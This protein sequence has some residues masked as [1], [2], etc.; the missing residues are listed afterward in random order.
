MFHSRWLLCV[1]LMLLAALSGA[2]PTAD[3]AT[4][5][6]DYAYDT[7][8]F[9]STG[10]TNGAQARAA[11]ESAASFYSGILADTLAEIKPL[12]YTSPR[13]TATW[14][15]TM[16]FSGPSAAGTISLVDRTIPTDEIRVYVGS[17][18][19]TGT[20]LAVGGPGGYSWDR[21]PHNLS[22]AISTDLTQIHAN[23]EAFESA[24]EDRGEDSG[25]ARWGGAISF[26]NDTNWHFNHTT[27]P[28]ADTTDFLTV[29]THEMAHV[30]GFGASDVWTSLV[31]G[32]NFNGTAAKASYGG[33]VPLGAGNGHWQDGITSTVFGGGTSQ[34]AT[35]VP[36]L[37]PATRRRL[38][39]LDAAALTDIGWSVVPPPGI[40]GDYNNNGIVD[41]GDY[42]LWRNTLGQG[43]AAGTGADGSGNG[44]VGNEDY[45]YWRTRFGNASA[46]AGGAGVMGGGTAVPE[47]AGILLT[48]IA[49]V[50]A[51]Y[52]C[53]SRR[54]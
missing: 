4:I 53:R 10:T 8:G 18:A 26:D 20:T 23:D 27:T 50:A 35:M 2:V 40:H 43:V 7:D 6:I 29:A 17:R 54:G 21:L 28:A 24:V 9:F 3:A 11:I 15:W 51:L 25:F 39:A 52:T 48:V 33:P 1:G 12:V 22:D 16:S 13:I 30:L 36:S 44:T 49:S 32:S 47:P 14:T 41:A 19:H 34:I 46:S 5:K 37:T 45:T 31:S 38:T 42:V